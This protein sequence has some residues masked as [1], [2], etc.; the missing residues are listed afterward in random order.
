MKV[1]GAVTKL[2]FFLEL[3]LKVSKVF[4]I[5]FQSVSQAIQNHLGEELLQDLINFCLSYMGLIKLPKKR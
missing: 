2:E 3:S 4:L 1:N 5:F